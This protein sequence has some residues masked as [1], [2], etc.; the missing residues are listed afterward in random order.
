MIGSERTDKTDD[1]PTT[2]EEYPASTPY[3]S[4][5]IVTDDAAG[6]AAAVV[7]NIAYISRPSTGIS[8]SKS[9]EIKQTIMGRIKSLMALK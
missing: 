9:F 4:A 5:I 3:V 2:N 1:D 6:R 7:T 8:M